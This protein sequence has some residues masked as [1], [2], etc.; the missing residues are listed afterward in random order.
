M[1]RTMFRRPKSFAWTFLTTSVS[2]TKNSKLP[3]PRNNHMGMET[4]LTNLEIVHPMEDTDRTVVRNRL[5][6]PA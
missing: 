5:K 3:H 4:V 6:F 1:T 2:N